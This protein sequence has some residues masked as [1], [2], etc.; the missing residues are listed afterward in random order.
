MANALRRIC[1]AEVPT[2]GKENVAYLLCALVESRVNNR[3]EESVQRCIG[4][5]KWSSC[6]QWDSVQTCK[7]V[8]VYLLTRR[9]RIKLGTSIGV[10][11][12]LEGIPWWLWW[13]IIP[14]GISLGLLSLYSISLDVEN[15]LTSLDVNCGWGSRHGVRWPTIS[16]NNLKPV[17]KASKE[18]QHYG[19][20]AWMEEDVDN[21]NHHSPNPWQITV[22]SVWNPIECNSI[23]FYSPIQRWTLSL[24]YY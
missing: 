14:L 4:L 12:S 6:I 7:W 19:I 23:I 1:I 13:S 11:G 8:W 15:S 24:P 5:Y 10:E 18:T 20:T 16:I 17:L 2:I 21:S 22:L 9:V 3:R